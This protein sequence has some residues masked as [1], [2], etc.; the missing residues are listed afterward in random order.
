MEN[1]TVTHDDLEITF[2]NITKLL[3][4]HK[5]DE[6]KCLQIIKS[7]IHTNPHGLKNIPKFIKALKGTIYFKG[8]A[9]SEK[10]NYLDVDIIHPLHLLLS[11]KNGIDE[12]TQLYDLYCFKSNNTP[13][14][15]VKLIQKYS[16]K[17]EITKKQV[18]I[19][20]LKL[21]DSNSLIM[22]NEFKKTKL[23]KDNPVNDFNN[24]L[25]STQ[26][27][28][29]HL[30]LCMVNFESAWKAFDNLPANTPYSEEK[31]LTRKVIFEQ[32]MNVWELINLELE[33]LKPIAWPLTNKYH[34]LY[35]HLKELFWF[36]EK[37]KIPVNKEK[38]LYAMLK[39]NDSINMREEKN[40]F[41]TRFTTSRMTTKQLIEQIKEHYLVHNNAQVVEG[42]EG[43]YSFAIYNGFR[44]KKIYDII[45]SIRKRGSE[46]DIGDYAFR[47]QLTL[48]I[49]IQEWPDWK[50]KDFVKDF[51]ATMGFSATRYIASFTHKTNCIVDIFSE[52]IWKSKSNYF[53]VPKSLDK[54]K[55]PKILHALETKY[56]IGIARIEHQERIKN[57][58]NQYVD[59][60]EQDTPAHKRRKTF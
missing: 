12:Y 18:E 41:Q 19:Y 10:A 47:C 32:N 51:M 27:S 42:L 56:H 45:E 50:V 15:R 11:L 46:N 14:L 53:S 33:M 23:Y 48:P 24:I 28:V 2:K 3:E 1:N 6:E 36:C 20:V 9:I 54:I 5:D 59:S 13:E 8:S 7:V 29:Q 37:F 31:K 30:L 34:I 22:Y 55:I 16:D 52:A 4:I 40:C 57:N 60:F 38:E 26:I 39:S 44:T 43:E 35:K 58:L 21:E 17:P 49:N 25:D